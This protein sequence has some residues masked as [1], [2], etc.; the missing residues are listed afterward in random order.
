MPWQARHKTR[1]DHATLITIVTISGL[2]VAVLIAA[3]L[4]AIGHFFALFTTT[5]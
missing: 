2:G 1:R 5:G 3:N 4:T